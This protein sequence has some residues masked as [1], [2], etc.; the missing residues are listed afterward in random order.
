MKLHFSSNAVSTVKSRMKW[1]GH[2]IWT[3]EGHLYG[4]IQNLKF[5]HCFVANIFKCDAP[6]IH[7]KKQTAKT[8][9][10]QCPRKQN[11]LWR[12]VINATNSWHWNIINFIKLS[13]SWNVLGYLSYW[14][15]ADTWNS[16]IWISI[17]FV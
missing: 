8:Q 4:E 17:T 10:Q 11:S 16:S 2:V 1:A 3:E 12:D 5:A 13:D 6:T 9:W 14:V 15:V 7:R